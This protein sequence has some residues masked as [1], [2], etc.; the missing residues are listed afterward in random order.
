MSIKTESNGRIV[1]KDE[2][3]AVAKR[4]QATL[5]G[6]LSDPKMAAEIKRALPEH[7]KPERMV[8]IALTALRGTPGLGKCTPESFLG[9]VLQASQL[10]LEVNTPMQHAYLIPRKSGELSARAGHEVTEC[11]LIVGYQ[12]MIELAMRSGKLLGIYAQVVRDGDDFEWELGL[13]PT[14]RHRPSS[15]ADR[16]S[17]QITHAYAVAR[18]KDA[19]PVFEVLS[20]SQLEARMARSGSVGKKS[21]PWT[22]DPDQM[23]RKS[24]I[25]AI[26]KWIPKS[27]EMATADHIEVNQEKGRSTVAAFDES[28]RASL[29]ANGLEPIDTTAD[30][31]E[32]D[33]ETGE[34]VPS[35]AQL[36]AARERQPGEDDEP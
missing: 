13:A 23:A 16:D 28:V 19:E 17:R 12:G 36:D 33:P 32:H 3:T 22:T 11:T 10:G 5:A 31:P 25:R 8:R 6:L 27:A 20:A 1:K 18:I 9:C 26:W 21:S 34:V 30:E 4:E 29:A 24:A 2:R 14:L 7:I 35:A 15:L